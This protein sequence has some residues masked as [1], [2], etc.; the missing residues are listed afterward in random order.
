MSPQDSTNMYLFTAFYSG[1]TYDTCRRQVSDK[2]RLKPTRVGLW[3][4]VVNICEKLVENFNFNVYPLLAIRM[5]QH[6]PNY[7]PF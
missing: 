3:E 7:S 6:V 1:F 4:H 2:C 5:A